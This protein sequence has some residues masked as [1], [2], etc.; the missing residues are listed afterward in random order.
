META[1][2]SNDDY[3]YI[4]DAE[5]A[6]H[7][8]I[9][10]ASGT[11]KSVF[12]GNLALQDIHAD[13]GV[14]F[15][16]PH[17]DEAE[18]LINSI[19]SHRIN[20]VCYFNLADKDNPVGFNPLYNQPDPATAAKNL[21]AALKGLFDHA[22]GERL[23]WFLYNGLVLLM[24][25]HDKTLLDLRPIYFNSAKRDK[26][27]LHISDPVT[28]EFWQQEYP[29]YS[30]AYRKEA[31][32]AILNKV[33]QFLASP[34]IRPVLS[35]TRPKLDINRIIDGSKI[36]IVNL[37]KGVIGTT[38]ANLI[39][40][41]LLSHIQ[42]IMMS[43]S[44]TTT[45]VPFHLYCDEFQTLGTT[46]WVDLLSEVRKYQ[47]SLTLANQFRSQLAPDLQAAIKANVATVIAFRLGDDDARELAPSFQVPLE[48]LS[49]QFPFEAWVRRYQHLT[50]TRIYTLPHE[51]PLQSARAV[52]AMSR[53][54]FAIVPP[55]PRRQAEPK[56]PTRRRRKRA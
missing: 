26:L 10:G 11:G 24:E 15:I 12:L 55:A 7:V 36:L 3:L 52:Q 13:K 50:T 40:S 16:D 42:T 27:T 14:C 38:N 49:G 47:L 56:P 1:K 34:Y 45:R 28:A 54:Q 21:T 41:L 39:G 30:P 29:S 9:T 4:S 6:R 33:G 19:P 17:G 31:Q 44:D 46:A 48:E 35:Q 43:K 37:A 2:L 20:D 5:R 25:K 32:G 18:Y 8:S 23:E 53:R 51:L 22:W